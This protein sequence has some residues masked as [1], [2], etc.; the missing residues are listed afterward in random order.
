MGVKSLCVVPRKE[1]KPPA[2][3]IFE[4]VYFARPDSILEGELFIG[5]F[6]V[7]VVFFF[8]DEDCGHN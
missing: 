1:N 2:F 6:F 4:Y 8:L 3:C 7:C 5:R